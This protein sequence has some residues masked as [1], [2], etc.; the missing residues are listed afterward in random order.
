MCTLAVECLKSNGMQ[1]VYNGL[2]SICI[3]AGICTEKCL[4]GG[5]CNQKDKCHCPKG[6]YGLRCEF[7]KC[8][9]DQTDPI[10]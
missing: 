6:Y 3:T 8:A 9:N 1:V 7:C 5:K 2:L 10:A 4:N